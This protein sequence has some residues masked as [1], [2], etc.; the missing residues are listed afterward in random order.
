MIE[1]FSEEIAGTSTFLFRIGN[2]FAWC[3]EKEGEE[4]GDWFT[5]GAEKPTSEQVSEAFDLLRQ[6]A[7]TKLS[8]I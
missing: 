4:V 5:L 6:Q 3:T 1:H 8:K 2:Y 7:V